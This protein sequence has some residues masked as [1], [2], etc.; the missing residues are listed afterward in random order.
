M[1]TDVFFR[2]YED[3]PLFATVGPKQKAL[4]VQAYRIINEQIWAYRGKDKKVD[5]TVKATWTVL[6]DRLTMELGI[7]DLSVRQY[8]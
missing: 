1:L 7:K 8:P 5:E 3:R 6:H 4:F 2:R